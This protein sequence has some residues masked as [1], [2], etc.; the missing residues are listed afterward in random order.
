MSFPANPINGT[1]AV[2]NGI[3]YTYVSASNAWIRSTVGVTS[4]NSLNIFGTTS[5][6]STATG[7]L[8]VAGGVGIGGNLY[9]GNDSIFSGNLLPSADSAYNLGTLL[10]RQGE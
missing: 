5:S 8:T 7:A 3:T 10:M 4:T 2:L 6:T 1:T 9:V